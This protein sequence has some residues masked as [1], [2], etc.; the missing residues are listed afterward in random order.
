MFSLLNGIKVIDLTTIVLGPYATQFLGDFGADIIK[1]ENISGDLFRTVRPGRSD[2]MGAGFINCNR[3][4]RSIAIDLKTRD[5]KNVL[6]KLVKEAD[7]VVHNMRTSTATRLGIDYESLKKINGEIVYCFAPGYG[8]N[9]IYAE[10]PAY[11]DIIQAESGL[12]YLNKS[13]DGQPRFIP[14]IICDK[15]GGMHLA[16]AVLAG[17]VHRLQHGVGCKLE[18]PMFE[19]MVS[20]LMTEQLAGESFVPPLGGTGYERLTSPYR[21]PFP[22]K[23]GYIS[24]LP[25]STRHWQK[26][27]TLIGRADM[28][29]HQHVTDPVIRSE[30]VGSLYKIV[31]ESTPAKTTAQWVDDLTAIDVPFAPV[32][33]IAS[34]LTDPHLTSQSFFRE[35][36]H[37]TE[38]RLR[39][40]GSPFYA[41]DVELSDNLPSPRLGEHTAVILQELGYEEPEINALEA[42]GVILCQQPLTC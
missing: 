41:E 12:A 16:M 19:G 38:G 21:K 9:G 8:Q 28:V 7:V 22:T 27:F 6:E 15:V 37:P 30:N 40:A 17:M 2:E 24:I 33:D 14:T 13:T 23:D 5:G 32:N 29:T 10:K 34:L 26:F 1:V 3:N 4:K 36:D 11:D 25:Y 39:E 18:A 31:S 20:F 42:E 35:Y